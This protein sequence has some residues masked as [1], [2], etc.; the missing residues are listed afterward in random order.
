MGRTC[1]D[2]PG[3]SLAEDGGEWW[4]VLPF[5]FSSCRGKLLVLP[6]A[7][8]P[9]LVGGVRRY[10]TCRSFFWLAATKLFFASTE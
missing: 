4:A 6:P 7:G 8:T 9:V 10:K 2:K 1:L 5:S 3:D